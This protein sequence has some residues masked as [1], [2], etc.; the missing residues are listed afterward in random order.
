MTPDAE[1]LKAVFATNRTWSEWA[2][3]A[4]FIG[5]LGDI[6][7]IFLF[8][9]DKPKSETWLAFL[10]TF[11]IAAGVYGESLASQLAVQRHFPC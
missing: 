1:A 9:K 3:V 10:C 4:V 5:L 11:I 8:S 6:L 2:T 7:V